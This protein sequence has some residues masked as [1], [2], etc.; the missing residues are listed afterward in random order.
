MIYNQDGTGL[1]SALHIYRCMVAKTWEN[2]VHL[3]KQLDGI[4]PQ[5]A[6]TLAD[7]GIQSLQELISSD[8]RRLEMVCGKNSGLPKLYLI[9]NHVTLSYQLLRRNPPFGTQVSR[10]VALC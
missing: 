3:L 4:G 10:I 7:S 1:K 2:S 9:R 5:Y 8:P 6:K